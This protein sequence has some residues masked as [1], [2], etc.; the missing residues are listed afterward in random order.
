MSFS[1]GCVA[2]YMEQ[3]PSLTS[4][5]DDIANMYYSCWNKHVHACVFR[6]IMRNAFR[7]LMMIWCFL[8]VCFS[9]RKETNRKWRQIVL[10]RYANSLLPT[11]TLLALCYAC[12]FCTYFFFEQ[13]TY[14]ISC[15]CIYFVNYFFTVPLKN[16]LDSGQCLVNAHNTIS[17]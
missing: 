10:H 17:L 15:G 4:R 9:D 6:R 1:W 5:Y 12:C 11:R 2:S 8:C 13:R 7:V 3:P 16:L 14:I